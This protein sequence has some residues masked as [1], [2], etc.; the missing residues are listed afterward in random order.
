MRTRPSWIKR[1]AQAA[2]GLVEPGVQD[3]ATPGNL[4]MPLL[5]IEPGQDFQPTRPIPVVLAQ[6]NLLLQAG[7]LIDNVV[8]VD[9]AYR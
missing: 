7:T 9:Q 3:T 1:A 4:S 2:S 6:L 8:G 5:L